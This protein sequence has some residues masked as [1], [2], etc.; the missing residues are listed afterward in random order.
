MN[1]L[2]KE[3]PYY[4]DGISAKTTLYVVF[5][6]DHEITCLDAHELLEHLSDLCDL[7]DYPFGSLGKANQLDHYIAAEWI[8]SGIAI[9]YY[10]F[11]S[12][13]VASHPTLPLSESL[14]ESLDYLSSMAQK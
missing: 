9:H 2:E 8:F 11:L 13:A 6:N 5:S 3:M 1:E 10:P 14:Q 4:R 12:H 7:S